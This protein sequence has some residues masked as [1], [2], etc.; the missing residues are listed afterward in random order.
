MNL[1][2]LYDAMSAN[3]PDPRGVLAELQRKRRRGRQRMLAASGGMAV[4]LVIAVIT[5][6]VVH[7]LSGGTPV[8]GMSSSAAV[9]AASAPAAGSASGSAGPQQNGAASAPRASSQSGQA[10]SGGT[11]TSCAAV[12]L[13]D[14]I[15]SAVRG[16]ASVIVATGKL[17]GQS[18]TGNIATAGAPAFY[19][20]TLSSVQTLRGPAIASG[21]TAWVP[22]P[23]P[24]AAVSP[25][26]SALLGPDGKVFAIA[27]PKAATH[28]LVGPTLRL[29][30]IVGGDVVFSSAGCWDVTG[31]QASQY[32]ARTPLKSVP[33]GLE[34]AADAAGHGLYAVPL[35]TVEQIA[36][37][38]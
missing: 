10:S 37:T 8:A 12:P 15:A 35:A 18:V 28:G 31:L 16:G 19:A 23:A 13:K 11:S 30:P 14:A 6:A 24:G 21:S 26:G 4:I 2:E 1:D 29:A 27:S 22:G 17:T 33:G 25:E 20:M 9:P 34:F 7:G 38:A 32:R 36:A 3:D 5:G